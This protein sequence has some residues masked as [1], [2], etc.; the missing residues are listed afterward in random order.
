[1]LDIVSSCNPVQYWEKLMMQKYEKIA[2][3]KK[4]TLG[5]I[6]VPQFFSEFYLYY[7]FFQ[8]IILW[9]LKN[10]KWTK[11]EKMA[12]NLISDSILTHQAQI[13]ILKF[14]LWVLPLL[15][16]RHCCNLSSYLISKK[17]SDPNRK[18]PKTSFWAWF[19]SAEPKFRL[20]SNFYKT[21]S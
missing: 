19:R 4:L 18:W 16:A 10:N 13:C 2:K 5:P 17:T 3:K 14:F 15:D 8:A 1:M 11:L 20:S 12:N 9:N 21:S 7:W 6:L